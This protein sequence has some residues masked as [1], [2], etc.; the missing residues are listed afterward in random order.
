MHANTIETTANQQGW[1]L[2]TGFAGGQWLETSSPAGEDLIIDVPSGRPI[3]ETVHEHAEQFDPDEHVRALVRS[4]MKG[5]PGTIAELLEDAKAIQTMLDRLDAALSAPPDD[6]PHWEQWTAEALDEM[7]DDV[8]HKA[9]SLAQTVLW[10]HH[11]ANHGIETPENTRR[12]CLDTLDD[13]RDLMNRDA[14]RHPPHMTEKENA[15]GRPVIRKSPR[16]HQAGGRGRPPAGKGAHAAPLQTPAGPRRRTPPRRRAPPS[17]TTAKRAKPYQ[18]KEPRRRHVRSRD[19][20]PQKG[21]IIASRPRPRRGHGTIPPHG[22]RP[23]GRA[24]PFL[25]FSAGRLRLWIIPASRNPSTRH[26]TGCARRD[27]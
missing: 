21:A 17:G 3:P 16:P 2:H 4:P 9:S 10:H 11:A 1:T 12:Q 20:R 27:R 26:A 25:F 22:T 7:L 18:T 13:L 24:G 14:S 8:A 19:A 23:K 6:D 5:Q 15:D